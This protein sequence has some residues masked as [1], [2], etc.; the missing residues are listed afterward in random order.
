M[1]QWVDLENNWKHYFATVLIQFITEVLLDININVITYD[2]FMTVAYNDEF[3]TYLF[4]LSDHISLQ[5]NFLVQ[6]L[7]VPIIKSIQI[8]LLSQIVSLKIYQQLPSH[9]YFS[10]ILKHTLTKWLLKHQRPQRDG[11]WK[12]IY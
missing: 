5:L 8:P 2:V 12:I 7:L 11:D 10:I 9:P 6:P 4:L 1:S 3:K